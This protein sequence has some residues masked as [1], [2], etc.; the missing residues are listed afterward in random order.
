MKPP[1]PDDTPGVVAHEHEIGPFV[2]CTVVRGGDDFPA[3]DEF[4]Y[5]PSSVEG[6]VQQLHRSV[7]DR[8]RAAFPDLGQFREP[9]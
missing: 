3:I 7:T 2:V 8:C 9:R 1:L 6:A 4:R 5:V